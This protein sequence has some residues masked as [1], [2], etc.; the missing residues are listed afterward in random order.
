MDLTL[1]EP[2][3]TD[4]LCFTPLH[5]IVIGLEQAD[6][7]QQL[8]LNSIYVNTLDSMGRSPLHWATIMGNSAAVGVLLEHGASPTIKDKEK[9]TP[10]H[11][12]F[13]APP[14]S[15]KQCGQLLLDSGA[16]VN[17]LDS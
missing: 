9:M 15:Q 17:A 5:H 3:V 7:R 2:S 13:L 6:L 10:L 16:E 14:S 4:D 12:I 1:D 11:N 8:R